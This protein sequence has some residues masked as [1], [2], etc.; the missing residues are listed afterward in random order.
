MLYTLHIDNY[1]G[2]YYYIGAL[3]FMTN[4][5]Q[6]RRFLVFLGFLG[7][8]AL[9]VVV[10][11]A[12]LMI[13]RPAPDQNSAISLPAV[14]RGPILDRNGRILA[15]TTR[16]YS[17][18]AW[19]PE[20]RDREGAAAL[21]AE[22]LGLEPG[23]TARRF[24]EAA[25]FL[26]VK[27]KITPTETER[28]RALQA[29]GRL[30]GI[31]LQPEFGRNYPNQS[32]A[33]HVLGY[34]GVD[35]VGLE[36]IEYSF[37]EVLS[38]PAVTRVR[39]EGTEAGEVFGSQV[40][41]TLDANIQHLA[42]RRALAA[43]R[44]NQA[45]S[46]FVL[47]QEARSG[48]LLAYAAVPD[49]DPNEYNRFP[50]LRNLPLSQAFEPG[51]VFKI[52]SIASFLQL[53]GLRP[54]D[55][56]TCTGLYEKRLA[57]GE[58]IRIRD[59]SAHGRVDAERILKYSCN[60]GAAYASERVKAEDF[61]RS[62]QAFGFGRPT[63][64]PLPGESAGILSVPARWSLR[65][66]ATIAFGQEISVSALQVLQAATAIA[67]G[68]LMLTPHIVRKIVSASGE[69]VK[70]FDREPVREVLSPETA[71]AVLDMMAA[72]TERGRHGP[73]GPG[74]RGAYLGQDRHRPGAGPR[75]GH[76]L[77]VQLHRLFSGHLPHGGPPFDRLRGDPQSQ[78]RCLFRE[79]DRRPRVPRRGRGPDR[80]PGH[81]PVRGRCR[82][83]AGVGARK[84]S[85]P[86]APG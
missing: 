42:E 35:N 58:T 24:R 75:H 33:S 5:T 48:E 60:V 22:T 18:T 43:L 17:V 16:L 20:V 44:D 76:L 40:F 71:R 41:L 38:P 50:A 79:P 13:F 14:E 25:G 2:P 31:N 65:T 63:G 77:A 53:G 64:L 34:V 26:F 12:Q 61:Y 69:P 57:D 28:I 78:G 36:G 73:P 84:A 9:L 82:R 81:P 56:F 30:K 72:A 62:L 55:T 52:F 8:G 11:L 83:A 21:L 70:E 47:V 37:N 86:A 51:S 4:D 32:L 54:G 85:A 27:R 67:N 1:G 19:L 29:E 3:A 80:L 74:G 66:K 7:L 45:E 10:R 46:V 59:L 68:G 15:I 49:F 6:R 23:E 39:G